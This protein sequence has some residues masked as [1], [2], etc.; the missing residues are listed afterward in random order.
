MSAETEQA[1]EAAADAA[2]TAAG[3][4][5]DA[6]AAAN[7]L[8]AETTGLDVNGLLASGKEFLV[9]QG[10]E[11]AV[12]IAAA[13]AIFIIGKWIVKA[14]VGTVRRMMKKSDMDE[15]LANFL[16]SIIKGIGIAFV[17]IAAISKLGVETT[18]LA[19][20]LAA[21]GLAIGLSLQGSLGNLAA[22]VM[23]IIF[24]P[25]AKGDMI[26]AGDA[27]GVV[28]EVGIF[29]TTLTTTDNKKVIV[30]NS[31]CISGNIT[32]YSAM[33]TRRIDMIVGCGYNDDLKKVKKV[34]EKLVKADKRILAEP[35]C[36]IAV[37]ELADSS[38]NFVCRPWV[39]TDD[40]WDVKF[41]LTQKIKEAFDKE[42]LS[43]PY[44]QSDVHMHDAAANNNVKAA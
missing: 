18:S 34:L 33:P 2:N 38:V 26:E 24:R 9:E 36:T 13:L 21:A 7:N 28:Q 6:A 15:T 39:A 42:G 16:C 43:I 20:I 22:G 5:K 11:W 4:A 30:P 32:N 19:A 10:P 29:T 1:V 23:I 31:G 14:L 27:T 41:D 37:S 40:Y 8:V 3:A 12:N 35:S 17:A 44:P 25:F